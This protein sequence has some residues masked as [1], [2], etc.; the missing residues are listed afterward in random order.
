MTGFNKAPIVVLSSIDWDAAWQRHQIFAAMFA[1]RGHRVF[2]VENTGFRDPHLRDAQRLWVKLRRLVSPQQVSHTNTIP[3]GVSLIAPQVLPPTRRVFRKLNGSVFIP[4]LIASLADLGL[5]E[6][7][8]VIVYMPS[9]TTVELLRRLPSA[10]VVYDCASNFRGHP[11][12]PKDLRATE[13]LLVEMSGVV[14]CDSDFLFEQKK[15][16]HGNVVQIHQGVAEDFF[17][18]APARGVSRFC[19]YGTWIPNLDPDYLLALA[20]AGFDVTIS[21]FLKGPPPPPHPKLSVLPPAPRE[22]LVQRLERFD[23]FLMPY[24]INDF[25]LGVIP[26]KIYECLAMGRPIIASPLPSLL[27]LAKQGLLYVGE[28]PAD[29]T[30]I[31]RDLPRTESEELCRRR[32][33]LAREHTHERQFERF[34]A[35]SRAVYRSPAP[36][37]LKLDGWAS[38]PARVFLRG[39]MFVGA[40]YGL[41]RA[42]ALVTQAV[43]GR[44]FGP[45]A[46]GHANLA[47][48]TAAFLQIAP[49]IGFPTALAKF[50]PDRHDDDSRSALVSTALWLF[51]GWASLCFL[52]IALFHSRIERMLDLPPPMMTLAG[53]LACATAVHTVV[54]SPLLGLHRFAARGLTEAV[55]SVA[56]TASL[57]ALALAGVPGQEAFVGAL[58]VGLALSSAFAVWTLK[59]LIRPRFDPSLVRPLFSFA[60]VASL[61]LVT[62]ACVLAPARLLLHAHHSARDVGIFSAYFTTT[63]QLGLAVLTMTASVLVPVAGDADSQTRWWR[64]LRR[65]A[66]QLLLGWT[67]LFSLLSAAALLMF[68]R[69]YPLRLDWLLM[70]GAAAALI[71]LHGIAGALLAARGFRGVT[72]SAAGSL[73]AGAANVLFSLLLVPRYGIDG[74]AAAL[75]A[76]YAL[77]ALCYAPAWKLA[78]KA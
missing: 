41:A 50:L 70:F 77:G 66:P 29:W 73:V 22:K 15:A 13:K 8:V 69:S 3:D 51:A 65:H 37:K 47:I 9:A 20:D 27:P 35:A 23:A 74:A 7:P 62:A 67:V 78:S 36:L 44:W 76:A 4:Q 24:R 61:N 57:L 38:M 55:Y 75:I 46:Y 64:A 72:L 42:V 11:N 45:E 54:A 39:F 1:Q 31:A 60:I 30:R 16:E 12:A 52:V 53:A 63:A 59:G 19:Y 25:M 10:A 28:T 48:A 6:A 32:I 18:A 33:A 40:L 71:L 2:F 21:G 58:C 49:I 43:A 34:L 56:A 5:K 14:V 26:A 17:D 68:G